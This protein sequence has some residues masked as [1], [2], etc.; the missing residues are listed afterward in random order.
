RQRESA[1]IQQLEAKAAREKALAELKKKR[2][3][4][5]REEAQVQRNLQQMGVCSVGYRWIKQPQG[6]R[7][8]GGTHF[9]SNDQL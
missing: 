3:E 1:R 7:C 6:Y 8:A 4:R 2:E 5:K 9:I